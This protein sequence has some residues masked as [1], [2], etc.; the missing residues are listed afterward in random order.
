MSPLSVWID[1]HSK[2]MRNA[3]KRRGNRMNYRVPVT[4]QWEAAPAGVVSL[5]NGFTRVVNEYGCLLVSPCEF[6]L[7][8]RLRVTNMVTKQQAS[9][10]VVWK[11]TERP[12]G[13]DLGVKL[14]EALVD[15]WGVNV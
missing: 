5:E 9:A 11:G 1:N 7:Q 3:A 15:F 4:I 12:D 14:T 13:W 6:A 8:Q 2:E 10:E